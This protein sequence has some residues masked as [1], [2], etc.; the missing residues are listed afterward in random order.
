MTRKEGERAYKGR[1]HVHVYGIFFLSPPGLLVVLCRKS[2][3]FRIKNTRKSI[4]C[5][6][7]TY[8][9][10]YRGKKNCLLFCVRLFLCGLV[11]LMWVFIAVLRHFFV[12]VFRFI[13]G[14]TGCCLFSIIRLGRGIH[15]SVATN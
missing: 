1:G 7:C 3:Y 8:R 9:D 10:V 12:G 14:K 2:A 15:M 13:Y 5:V 4:P 11:W 6:Q